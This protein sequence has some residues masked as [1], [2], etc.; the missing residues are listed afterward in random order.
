MLAV[1][2]AV[3]VALHQ[4]LVLGAEAGREK[5]EHLGWERKGERRGEEE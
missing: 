3:L 5:F 4:L 1:V 2:R